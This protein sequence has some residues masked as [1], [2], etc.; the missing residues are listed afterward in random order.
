MLAGYTPNVANIHDRWLFWGRYRRGGGSEAK[1]LLDCPRH[2][3]LVVRRMSG[4]DGIKVGAL[5]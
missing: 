5:G 3:M 2:L 1:A 4:I